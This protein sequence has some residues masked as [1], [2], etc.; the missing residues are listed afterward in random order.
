M[1]NLFGKNKLR[2]IAQQIDTESIIGFVEVV[3]KW[4][5]DYHFGSLKADKETSREQQYNRDFFL[6]ILGYEEKPASPYSFVPKDTSDV[7]QLPDA[8]ISYADDSQ[9]V[10][11]IA[12]VVELKG[13]SID[14]DRPQRRDGN[15]S[16]V[17]QGFKYKSQYRS[18]PF[19]V[20]SNFWEF[21]LY[22]DNLL[23]YEVWTLDDLVNP[24]DDYLLFKTW[25]VLLN[26]QNFTTPKG[27]SKTEGILSDIRIEQENIS[28]KFYKVYREAR[29]ELLRDIYRRN[30][31]V[32][33]NIDLG[34]EKAQKVIDRIV[35]AAFAEDSGLLPDNTL[36]SVIASAD[37]SSFGG[38]LWNEL[39]SF[40]GAIDKG[41]EKLEIPDG[42]NGGLFHFDPDLD[43]LEIDDAPLRKVVELGT[44]NFA[45]DLS[46]NIL[47]HIF[48][49]S[50]SDLEEIKDKVNESN[51]LESIGQSRR[52]KDGIFYTPDYIVR[53]IV[54]NS[55]GV[56]LREHEEKFKLEFGLKGDIMDKTYEK[57]E[58]QAYGKYQDFLQNV[59][60]LDPACGSGAFLV[61]VFDYLLAENKRVGDILG[62]TLFSTDTW[63][64][65]ILR[66]NI[67]GV[68]LNEES[69]EITKLSLWLKTAQKGKKL[70]TL[71]ANI[72]C[73]NSL[74]DDPDIAGDK[75]F[76]W[77]EQFADVFKNGG[78]D[79]IV[80]NPPYVRQELLG[81]QKIHFEKHYKVYA[82]TTDLFAYFY[83]KA[84]SLLKPNGLFSFISNTF[85]K[86]TGSGVVL[87]KYLKENVKIEQLVDFNTL[88]I[89]Q[90]AT[91]YPIILVF[92][93]VTPSGSFKYLDVKKSDLS[94]LD[95]AFRNGSYEITQ[96][97]LKDTGW[98]FE[99]ASSAELRQKISQHSTVREQYGKS[100]RGILTG[101][102]EAFIINGETRKRL[103]HEDGASDE[104]IKPFLEGKDIS[105]WSSF[106]E[107][108]YVIYISQGTTKQL[109]GALNSDEALNQISQKY[110]A[111]FDY[112]EQ[113]A[114]KAEARWDKGDYWWEMR[115]CAYE[116][117]FLDTKITWTNLQNRGKFCYD[118]SGK[119]INA[120]AVILPSNDK[121]LLGLLN[122]KLVWFFLQ[123]ICVQRSGGYLEVKPQYFEQIPIPKM[124]EV[125]SE[126]MR[127]KVESMFLATKAK[128]ISNQ[129]FKNVLMSEFGIERWSSKLNRWWTLDFS[130]FVS[131]LKM[132]LSLSQKDELV[133]L[134]EKYQAAVSSLDEE[135]QS[136]DREIDH[137]VYEL[138]ELTP[139]EVT[140]VEVL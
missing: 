21:R 46:V 79:V 106:V 132:K 81:K 71:D 111:V 44:Y 72:K 93:N 82:G 31:S 97:S 75:A 91:T 25:F 83:E 136:I 121:S 98:N 63:V 105:R 7:G 26:K 15:L 59:K 135:I 47:G 140:T 18:V 100:Y 127:L 43:T 134:F 40:F 68:D 2:Q 89:F 109:F 53:Y 51:S 74:V 108:K 117:L 60:V 39:K 133:Q 34:I 27:S 128:H 137:M 84:L 129:R 110:R 123:G 76:N 56:Y 85:A 112:L 73:G 32:R 9:G 6:D 138:Y 1:A 11:N 41:S 42:Y 67:Y 33:D 99:S 5:N 8:L 14:L 45:E 120:P 61:Y 69:V 50:I 87:R 30:S 29:L 78:F 92:R 58:K 96:K 66:N 103:I 88:T 80:G 86:T 119:Y 24:E 65:D 49:Q 28:K 62:N 10:R 35:F 57:R 37:N 101:L 20:V 3:R 95:T 94:S 122:S 90:G 64:R 4:Q 52:K 55:L 124:S 114:L 130:N 125:W 19:V 102:N 116:S 77:N 113:F 13:A 70:T 23:D 16:P 139:A 115:A 12:A 36:Q 22:H 126:A 131:T 54:D 48:E 107:D 17:Q 104:V 118:E 38:T